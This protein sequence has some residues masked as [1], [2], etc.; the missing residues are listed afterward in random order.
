MASSRGCK[1][2]QIAWVV[3]YQEYFGGNRGSVYK[4]RSCS[5][6]NLIMAEAAKNNLAAD[7]RFEAMVKLEVVLP[8]P[9]PII[10]ATVEV[11][12]SK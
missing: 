8:E 6:D 5:Y 1:V 4:I 9:T 10:T 11:V 7:K 2:K 12:W 3:F